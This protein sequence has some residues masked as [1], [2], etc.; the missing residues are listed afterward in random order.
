M[1]KSSQVDPNFGSKQKNLIMSTSKN[2]ELDRPTEKKCLVSKTR[3]EMKSEH[4][5]QDRMACSSKDKTS[6]IRS[7]SK[8]Q[9][10]VL[11]PQ[12]ND[13]KTNREL[14]SKLKESRGVA[15]CLGSTIYE[16]KI[17]E[18]GEENITSGS[19]NLPENTHGENNTNYS[20]GKD[21]VEA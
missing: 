16:T 8:H 2:V 3:S 13:S 18:D 7:S 19:K 1:M 14:L 10:D 20:P 9:S 12:V 17:V 4:K 5:F 15:D 21:N 6:Q 11:V